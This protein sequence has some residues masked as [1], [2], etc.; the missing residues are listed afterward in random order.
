M[1]IKKILSVFIVIGIVLACFSFMLFDQN[2]FIS[3]LFSYV[4]STLIMFASFFSFYQKSKNTDAELYIEDEDEDEE[5]ENDSESAQTIEIPK[6]E[7]EYKKKR[8]SVK[9]LVLGGSL[10]FS[11]YRLF[12]YGFFIIG[13]FVLLRHGYFAITGFISGVI[14]S[15]LAVVAVFF[16]TQREFKA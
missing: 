9:N 6:E 5:F 15:T 2:G 13:F 16:L 1:N 14:V 12:A 4:S 3:S 8:F 10:F 7:P 11:L